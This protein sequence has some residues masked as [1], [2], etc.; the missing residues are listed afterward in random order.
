MRITEYDFHLEFTAKVKLE[1][2]HLMD[3]DF[4][5]GPGRS[6]AVTSV[7]MSHELGIPFIPFKGWSD[8]TFKDKKVLLVDTVSSTGK[9][10]RKAKS[11]IEK[12][13]RYVGVFYVFSHK[14]GTPRIKFWYEYKSSLHSLA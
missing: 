2:L 4:V 6:G 8:T 1:A 14:H 9:T 13:A 11:S 7:Y 3:F 5:T 10:L 12:T